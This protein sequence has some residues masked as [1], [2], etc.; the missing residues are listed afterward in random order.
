[1]S[2]EKSIELPR[3]S[4]LYA[5]A[6]YDVKGD[7]VGLFFSVRPGG[8]VTFSCDKDDRCGVSVRGESAQLPA[9]AQVDAHPGAE[10]HVAKVNVKVVAVADG[11][12][13][14]R[15]TVAK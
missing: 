5:V 9:S 14:L 2:R 4:G 11:K 8:S 12:A 10:L 15:L 7:E 3:S 13:V 6:A 1:M